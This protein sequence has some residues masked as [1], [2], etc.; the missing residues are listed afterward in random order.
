MVEIL[1]HQMGLIDYKVAYAQACTSVCDKLIELIRG[2]RLG[3]EQHNFVCAFA[4]IWQ[5]SSAATVSVS[6]LI[7]CADTPFLCKPETWK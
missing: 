7:V 1:P 5:P 2:S 3:T 4:Q 6:E